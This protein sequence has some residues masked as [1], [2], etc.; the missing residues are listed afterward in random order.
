M[1]R[2][3][4]FLP[5]QTWEQIGAK[6]VVI[7][8]SDLAA[9]GA[10]PEIFLS[11]L[12]LERTLKEDDLK[13]IAM[14]IQETSHKYGTR[15]L[16]GD[17]GSST[18]TVLT[19]VGVGSIREGK[20]LTRREAK[21]GDI[22]CV[23]GQFGLTSLGLDYLL[24]PESRKFDRISDD[25]LKLAVELL[26]EPHP[27]IT[28]GVLLSENNLATA[29]IDSSDGLAISLHWLSEASNVG[30]LIDKLPIHPELESSLDSFEK[31]VKSTMFG[32]EEY[33]LVFT[34]PPE[35]ITNLE[36]LFQEHHCKFITIGK[37]I[38]SQGVFITQ[39]N[40]TTSIPMRG[41]DTFRKKVH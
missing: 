21:P 4:D 11:S 39:N 29:S 32:G 25:L 9:K 6:L 30:F 13:K 31:I 23:T 18:E 27:R 2:D 38:D 3:S 17:L 12:V 20:I 15:Y 10:K 14:S 5:L 16:G 36:F 37:C 35:K 24:S 34:I 33:E 19:G 40:T 28:E 26:Y 22:V 7:T 8:F 1:S 41:W